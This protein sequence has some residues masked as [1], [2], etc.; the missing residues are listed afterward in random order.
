MVEYRPVPADRHVEF[1]QAVEYAFRPEAG[2]R[3]G[4]ERDEE[5]PTRIGDYRG[6]FDGETLLSGCLLQSF[7]ARLRGT[8]IDLGG[9]T[10]VATPPEHRR[11]GYVE[12][13]LRD[14]LLE[15]RDREMP[16][17]ALWPFKRSFYRQFGWGTANKYVRYDVDPAALAGVSED[18]GAGQFWRASPDDWERLRPVQLAHGEDVT[19]SLRRSEAW[20]RHRTFEWFGEKRYVYAWDDDAGETAG[21]VV[22]DIE[23]E[24]EQRTLRVFDTSYRSERAYRQLL[25][26]LYRHDSQ[27][28]RID[29]PHREGT[30]LLDRVRD[31]EAIECVIDAGPMIRVADVCD[32]L[33]VVPYPDGIDAEVTIAVADSLL[34]HNDGTVTLAV[35]DGEGR[36]QRETSGEADVRTDVRTLSQVLVGYHDVGDAERLGEFACADA[37]TRATLDRLFPP[38]TVC[39]REYF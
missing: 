37:Q 16:F 10:A 26:F 14:G 18:R 34:D 4:D 11:N 1:Q 31:T 24:G 39:L 27:V 25:W 5:L 35:A 9:F 19:L 23:S 13:L 36:C 21:Y 7:D 2:P 6:V 17:I 3:E 32:A 15:F 20:W 12:T 33:E 38:E 29:L 30:D 22:Y 8:W 28:T